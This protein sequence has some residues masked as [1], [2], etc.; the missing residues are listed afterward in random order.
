MRVSVILHCVGFLSG[1]RVELIYWCIAGGW[2]D[3]WKEELYF[4][5]MEVMKSFFC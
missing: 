1:E 4:L 2:V 3:G 5:V